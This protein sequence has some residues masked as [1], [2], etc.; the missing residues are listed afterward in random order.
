MTQEQLAEAMGISVGAVSKWESGQMN[1]E[2]GM[3]V[4]IADF[5][6]LSVDYL[7]GYSFKSHNHTDTVAMIKSFNV[8][9]DYIAAKEEIPKALL[10][11]PNDFDI[12]YYSAVVLANLGWE[13]NDNEALVQSEK[14][15]E[16]ACTLIGQNKDEDI[17]IGSIKSRIAIILASE[18]KY[19]EAIS[20]WKD[21]NVNGVNNARIGSCYTELKKYD[22][23]LTVLSESYIDSIVN[24]YITVNGLCTCFM[25]TKRYKEASEMVMW[26]KDS[27]KG[28]EYADKPSYLIK[29]GVLLDVINLIVYYAM[30]EKEA[31]YLLMK[32]V[33]KRARYFDS[34]PDFSCNN[35]KFYSGKEHTFYDD[36]GQTAVES[37]TNVFN[38]M[39]PGQEKEELI[40]KWK[41][42]LDEK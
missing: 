37:V 3:I 40:L 22:E 2:I 9:K 12:V 35:I 32:E 42:V 7:L 33:L 15:F 31:A 16:H 24:M 34:I 39:D 28:L 19:E 11:Y 10:K 20:L 41:E 1:P 36:V 5:F 17:S 25:N 13:R 27:L 14:L 30:N 18:D 23:A 29:I 21:Y 8:K 38:M 6:G 4:K 26:L